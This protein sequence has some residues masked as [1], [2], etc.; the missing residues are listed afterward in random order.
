MEIIVQPVFNNW[1]KK[2]V[3]PKEMLPDSGRTHPHHFL[4]TPADNLIELCGRVCYDSAKLKQTRDSVAY[5]K[6]INDVNHGSTQEHFNFT[7]EFPLTSN[8]RA[9]QLI[10][11]L[12]NR[13]GIYIGFGEYDTLR[14]TANIRAINE[15]DKFGP[16]CPVFHSLYQQAMTLAPFATINFKNYRSPHAPFPLASPDVPEEHWLS[17]YIG[18]VSRGMINEL[19]R[20]KFHAAIS[21]R[22]TR[23]VDESESEWAFHPLLLKYWSELK[24][25]T[26]IFD[27]QLILGRENSVEYVEKHCRGL[28]ANVAEKLQEILTKKNVSKFQAIKQSRGAARGLLGNALSTELIYSASLDEIRRIILQRLRDGADAEIRLFAHKLYLS[29]QATHPGFMNP[30]PMNLVPAE[31]GIGM[32][33]PS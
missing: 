28:Y 13:P 17:F 33:I 14:I 30:E 12:L 5:H 27:Q 10:R 22:S 2:L 7:V 29:T 6:H 31:D 26:D 3:I 32:V 16:I 20:H 8:E 18:G 1:D 15:W 25:V 11:P 9:W 19:V 4:S 23:Y 24:G 21:Q